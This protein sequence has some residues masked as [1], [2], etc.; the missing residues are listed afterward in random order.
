ML[1]RSCCLINYTNIFENNK[2]IKEFQNE[3][4]EGRLI[5]V[6]TYSIFTIISLLHVINFDDDLVVES[7]FDIIFEKLTEYKKYKESL[8][9]KKYTPH[10]TTIKCYSLFLNRYCF[11]YSIKND[12]DLYNS[13]IHFMN[14]YPKSKKLNEFIFK[15]LILFFGFMTS[16]LY[17]FFTN[18]KNM[19][20][21]HKIY[22]NHKFIF[23]KCDV[24]LFQYLLIQPEIKEQFN[25]QNI[26]MLS[27]IKASNQ[28]FLKLFN[29][30]LNINNI[31]S[32]PKNFQYINSLIEFLYLMI[33]DNTSMEKMDSEMWI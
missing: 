1:F 5:N 27:D 23:I 33:R 26:S 14:I 28:N 10:L 30:D 9:I 6:E 3:G 20:N 16:Q 2:E 4:F 19:E 32:E 25:I 24:T 13:F 18:F 15:E 29:N 22:F 21:Y 31:N 11:N 8:T 12:Y 17:D 7:I